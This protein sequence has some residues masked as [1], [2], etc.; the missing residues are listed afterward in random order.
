MDEQLKRMKIQVEELTRS[1]DELTAARN[2]LMQ[3]NADLER[4]VHD[5]EVSLDTFTKNKSQAQQ[6][7]ESTQ[8]KLEEEIRVRNSR[9]RIRSQLCCL[10]AYHTRLLLMT[11]S[12]YYVRRC[13]LLL[14]IEYSMV[15]RSVCHTSEPCKTAEPIEIPFGLR[16]RVGPGNYVLHGGPDP[17]HGMG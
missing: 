1:K 4:Q 9:R 2:S 11:A 17:P 16:T 8:T 14:P 6:K 5:L 13:G 3:A 15:C 7:L 10:L 12:Q